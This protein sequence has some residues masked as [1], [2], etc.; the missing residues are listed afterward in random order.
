MSEV[1]RRDAVKVFAAGAAIAVGAGAARA[2]D[3]GSAAPAGRRLGRAPAATGR[4]SERREC[5][6]VRS[7]WVD[8]CRSWDGQV[9]LTIDD[10]TRGWVPVTAPAMAIAAA[11]RA[12]GRP[13][14]VRVWG[15]EPG[16]DRGVGRFEGALIAMDASDFP[17]DE[18]GPA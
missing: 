2:G 12:A 1:S 10:S 6:P 13:A 11:C 15:H 5:S 9:Y 3:V 14:A 17:A 18:P 7:A 4:A 8:R 16:F